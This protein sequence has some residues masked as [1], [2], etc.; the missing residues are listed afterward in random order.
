MEKKSLYHTEI[1]NRAG[2]NGYVRSLNGG[3]F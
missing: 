3:K 1:E 2:L